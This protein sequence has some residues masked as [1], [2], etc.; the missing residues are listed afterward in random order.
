MRL[1]TTLLTTAA[2]ASAL[3]LSAFVAGGSA[4][5]IEK[6]SRMAVRVALE[7]AGVNWVRAEADGLQVILLGTAPSEAARFRAITIAGTPVGGSM[8][9]FQ[10][11][12]DVDGNGTAGDDDLAVDAHL[13]G[14][15]LNI[16]TNAGTDD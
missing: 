16:T 13:I 11:Y 10:V 5:I 14:I 15:T 7:S 1:R 6:R 4:T 2:V 3:V 12:R 8:V 9:C